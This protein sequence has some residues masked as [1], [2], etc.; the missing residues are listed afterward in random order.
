LGNFEHE[1]E[2]D[3]EGKCGIFRPALS[4]I[5]SVAMAREA[6]MAWLARRGAAFMPLQLP[7][8]TV[9]QMNSMPPAICL[10]KRHK[11]RAPAAVQPHG[12]D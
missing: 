2:D 6:A 1:N 8:W 3:E 12:S 7:H 4:R 9:A 10:V 5:D 11:C